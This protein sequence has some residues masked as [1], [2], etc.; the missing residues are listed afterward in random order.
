MLVLSVPFLYALELT[1]RCTNRCPGCGNV[2]TDRTPQ[3]LSC[4]QW[5]RVL[6]QLKPHVHRLKLTGGEPTLHP[7]FATIVSTIH[8]LGIPFALFTNA[9]WPYPPA[10]I[11][12][13]RDTPECRGL[14]V[15]LHGATAATHDT[16]TGVPGSFDEMIANVK[17]A[18]AASLV[19][20]TNTVITGHNYAEIGDIIQLSRAVG[21]RHVV[22]NR[23]LGPPLPGI[24]PTEEELRQAVQVIDAERR[25]AAGTRQPVVKFGNCIPQCFYP[26]SSTGCLAGVAYCT[27]DPWGNVRP[28]NHAPLTCGNLLERSLE[29]IWHGPAMERWRNLVPEMCWQCA[30][31]PQCRGGCR[32][33][34]MIRDLDADPLMSGPLPAQEKPHLELSLYAG[35]R[36]IGRFSRR[37]EPFGYV[38]VRGTHIVLVEAQVE[39]ILNALDGT[40]TL[41]QVREKFGQAALDF[42]GSLYR[43]GLVEMV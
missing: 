10:L 18:V 32:A 34:A 11:A 20:N 2:F 39:P 24:E 28:C 38:L 43:K 25:L 30:E 41:W 36:P 33:Q 16:F 1:A 9:R 42:L 14:L 12:L 15:S 6:T 40:L 26:S 35:S 17:R 27:V 23:Y 31:I 37:L 5:R 29:D 7:E 22:F 4:A 21:A 13:L 8:E 19:V 3:P